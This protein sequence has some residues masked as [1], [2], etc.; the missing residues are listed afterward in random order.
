MGGDRPRGSLGLQ[1]SRWVWS[2]GDQ[3]GL[4]SDHSLASF[5]ASDTNPWAWLPHLQDQGDGSQGWG[6]DLR[7]FT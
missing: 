6:V 3:R 1:G 7:R 5:L 2:P 4:V